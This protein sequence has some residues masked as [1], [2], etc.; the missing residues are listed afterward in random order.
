MRT[1]LSEW[2]DRTFGRIHVQDMFQ[3][4]EEVGATK[5]AGIYLRNVVIAL[6]KSEGF[7]KDWTSEETFN[8]WKKEL[9]EIIGDDGLVKLDLKS[10]EGNELSYIAGTK[11]T[12]EGAGKLI[13]AGGRLFTYRFT[14]SIIKHVRKSG[15]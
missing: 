7:K 11:G 9:R 1:A 3:L 15:G 2:I 8:R 5:E 4:T 14:L 6:R 13:D 10:A 12:K